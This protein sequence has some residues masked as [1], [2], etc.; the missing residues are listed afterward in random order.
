MANFDS[1][2]RGYVKAQATVT[3]YFPIDLKGNVEI[4]C[5][6]CE[7]YVSSLRKCGLNQ[8][9]VNFPERYVGSE[10]P[11]EQVEVNENV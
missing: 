8:K 11:L 7:Y 9:I 3:V 5:K 4:A 2:V 1:G 6:H 10:C